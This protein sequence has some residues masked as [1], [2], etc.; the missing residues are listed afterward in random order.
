MLRAAWT[1][2]GKRKTPD[3]SGAFALEGT[4]VPRKE[5]QYLLPLFGAAMLSA[6]KPALS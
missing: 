5:F 2:E 4:S 3:C 6:G 1:S